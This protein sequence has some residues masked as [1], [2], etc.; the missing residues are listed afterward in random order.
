MGDF[1]RWMKGALWMKCL[2]LYEEAPWRG[3]GG[4]PSLGTLED[5]LGKSPDMGVS[6]YGGPFP[7]KGNLDCEGA[8]TPG[9][10][11]D[12][13]RRAV[14]VGHLPGR[15]SMKGTLG[16]RFPYQEPIRWGF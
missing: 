11:L 10:L 8:H 9:T 7:V 14:V 2:S 6:L 15:D 16:G 12:G 4:A 1:E 5:V 13:W 3:F